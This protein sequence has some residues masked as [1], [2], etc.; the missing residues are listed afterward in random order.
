M[1]AETDINLRFRWLLCRYFESVSTSLQIS[2]LCPRHNIT[3]VTSHIKFSPTRPSG[4]FYHTY[5]GFNFQRF[6]TFCSVWQKK[7]RYKISLT[8]LRAK[9]APQHFYRKKIRSIQSC[10][11]DVSIT[12]VMYA[13][14]M[15]S[16]PLMN[17]LVCQ[18]TSGSVLNTRSI[19]PF[20]TDLL[21]WISSVSFSSPELESA[22]ALCLCRSVWGWSTVAHIGHEQFF[23][24]LKF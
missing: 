4:Q 9:Y 20:V 1:Q 5:F 24:R 6:T 15:I 11:F 14:A 18:T 13:Q 3:S 12:L 17:Y 22:V 7:N 16:E 19:L 2:I 23:F 21:L 10:C 8:L